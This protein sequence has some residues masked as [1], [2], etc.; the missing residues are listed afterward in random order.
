MSERWTNLPSVPGL[1]KEIAEA[2]PPGFRGRPLLLDSIATA[3]NGSAG[4][5]A[6][7]CMKE[8]IDRNTGS[9]NGERSWLSTGTP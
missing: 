6:P 1:E 8:E 2:D 3:S 9:P 4:V 7:A 5:V